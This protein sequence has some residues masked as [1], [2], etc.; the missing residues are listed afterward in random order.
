MKIRLNEDLIKMIKH[1][2]K[3]DLK[4]GI[5][6]LLENHWKD[7]LNFLQ[8][9]EYSF[10]IEKVDIER[11]KQFKPPINQRILIEKGIGTLKK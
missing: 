2:L 5:D 8:G 6:P 10:Y 11:N 7:V 9:D 1:W 4:S 3:D